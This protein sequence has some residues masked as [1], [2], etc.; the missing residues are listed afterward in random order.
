[1][2]RTDCGLLRHLKRRG[3]VRVFLSNH[4]IL[5]YVGEPMARTPSRSIFESTRRRARRRAS[6]GARL[7]AALLLVALACFVAMA[8]VL[9]VVSLIAR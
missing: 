4:P 6:N 5:Q 3:R 8:G 2:P 9:L 1:M 7:A